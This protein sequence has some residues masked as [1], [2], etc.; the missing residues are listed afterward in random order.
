VLFL[1]SQDARF[2]SH[3]ISRLHHGA[4]KLDIFSPTIQ[5]RVGVT[6]GT[7]NALAAMYSYESLI[8]TS[9]WLGHRSA[10]G[11]LR[12]C[13][14]KQGKERGMGFEIGVLYKSAIGRDG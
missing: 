14:G 5:R 7:K 3:L 11:R 13:K 10:I 8:A 9:I 4:S 2:S 6:L 12:K 1:L